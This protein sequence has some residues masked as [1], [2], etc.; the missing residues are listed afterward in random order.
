[1][2]LGEN[3][4]AKE[5]KPSPIYMNLDELGSRLDHLGQSLKELETRLHPITVPMD[6]PPDEQEVTPRPLSSEI[7]NLLINYTDTVERYRGQVVDILNKL[8][9]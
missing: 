2:Q 3:T 6:S 7:V 4:R 5:V 8:E 9:V 1:M